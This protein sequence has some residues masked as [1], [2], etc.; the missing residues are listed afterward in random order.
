MFNHDYHDKETD[1]TSARLLGSHL[2]SIRLDTILQCTES[3]EQYFISSVTYK[4]PTS[5]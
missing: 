3:L 5:D 2:E 4:A 1:T